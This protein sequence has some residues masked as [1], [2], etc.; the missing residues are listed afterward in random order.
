MVS[1][2]YNR[3]GMVKCWN[4]DIVK[5]WYGVGLLK[6]VHMV[7][8][9]NSAMIFFI[10]QMVKWWN[11]YMVWWW[12]GEIFQGWFFFTTNSIDG[13]IMKRGNGKMV[14]KTNIRMNCVMRSNCWMVYQL[15]FILLDFLPAQKWFPSWL[16]RGSSNVLYMVSDGIPLILSFHLFILYGGEVV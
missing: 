3:R 7:L 10:F 8:G 2:V 16:L 9:W 11:H 4:R 12:Y 5:W 14:E 15:G 1:N 13:E 6:Y